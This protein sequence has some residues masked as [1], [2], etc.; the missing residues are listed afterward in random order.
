MTTQLDFSPAKAPPAEPWRATH[1]L[2]IRAADSRRCLEAILEGAG[3]AAEIRN[4]AL[5][6]SGEAVEAT[7]RLTELSCPEAREVCAQIADRP[8]IQGAWIEHHLLISS[9]S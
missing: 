7:L 1:V 2:S 8:G 4:L 5:K 9:P 6:T 3:G